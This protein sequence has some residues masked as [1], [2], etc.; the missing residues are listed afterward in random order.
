MLY[1][2]YENAFSSRQ[3]TGA[4]KGGRM[5]FLDDRINFQMKNNKITFILFLSLLSVGGFSRADQISSPLVFDEYFSPHVGASFARSL[6][7]MYSKALPYDSERQSHRLLRLLVE[8]PVIDLNLAVINHEVFGHGFRLREFNAKNIRYKIKFLSGSAGSDTAFAINKRIGVTIGGIEASDVMAKQIRRD[9][10]T[11]GSIA[12]HEAPMYF[13]GSIDQLNYI[14]L[15]KDSTGHDINHYV[16][17]INT[18]YGKNI[19]TKRKLKQWASLGFLDPFLWYSMISMGEYVQSNQQSYAFP[20]LSLSQELK[21]LPGLRMVLTPHGPEAQFNNYFKYKDAV[22]FELS[23]NYGVLSE[24]RS[25]SIALESS[26]LLTLEKTF[27]VGA[28]FMVWKQP[29]IFDTDVNLITAAVKNKAG[30]LLTLLGQYRVTKHAAVL[31]EAGY[32]TAGFAQA[33]KFKGSPIFRAGFRW[34][35]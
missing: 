35:A 8:L 16:S 29:K 1:E 4:S 15:T 17:E 24:R 28:R 2:R 21:Y 34:H 27:D 11:S 20:M 7:G 6:K 14:Y 13:A 23:V 5:R 26:R 18:L 22:P 32:K 12:L 31:M 33:E 10:Q 30:G 9:W 3:L 19:L 25:W